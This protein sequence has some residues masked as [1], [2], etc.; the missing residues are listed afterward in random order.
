MAK[1]A[2]VF[3]KTCSVIVALGAWLAGVS[4]QGQV[5]EAPATEP[6]PPRIVTF[7]PALSQFVVDLGRGDWIV[8]VADHD[9]A[10]PEGLPVVGN[11]L[12]PHVERLLSLRPTH[13]L[14]MVGKEGPDARLVEW[15]ARGQFELLLYPTPHSV[16]EILDMLAGVDAGLPDLGRALHA[17]GRARELSRLITYRLTA[18]SQAVEDAAATSPRVLL[19]FNPNPLWASGPGSVEDD[20]LCNYLHAS[21]AAG[22][23]GGAAVVLDRERLLELRPDVVLFMLPGA[24]PI[25][26]FAQD[27]RLSLFRGLDVPAVENNRFEV[28]GDPRVLLMQSTAVDQIA[29]RLAMAIY[30]DKAGAIRTIMRSSP[31]PP[32]VSSAPPSEVDE[33]NTEVVEASKTAETMPS[34]PMTTP[35]HGSNPWGGAVEQGHVDG[36]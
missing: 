28:I 26:D 6:A 32:E 4:V 7:S 23:L 17:Q 29:A 36:E 15:A 11:Y 30:P 19:V 12:A 34:I 14:A 5:V 18:I 21:N 20:L 9:T 27:V 35:V 22:D 16:R 2:S 1:G 31:P 3:H 13:V 10:A 24:P 25:D 33:H 8:G